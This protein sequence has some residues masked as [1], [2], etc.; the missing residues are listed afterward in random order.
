[1]KK[2]RWCW[3]DQYLLLCIPLLVGHGCDKN[4]RRI[5]GVSTAIIVRILV[6]YV[7]CPWFLLPFV[8][9]HLGWDRWRIWRCDIVFAG[10]IPRMKRTMKRVSS[11]MITANCGAI[12]NYTCLNE[13]PMRRCKRN[14]P[15][16]YMSGVCAVQYYGK[17]SRFVHLFQP[18]CINEERM[19]FTS[20]LVSK[21]R[22][23][24]S[25]FYEFQNDPRVEEACGGEYFVDLQA[26]CSTALLLWLVRNGIIWIGLR[27]WKWLQHKGSRW[28]YFSVT[29][30]LSA[31]K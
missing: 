15:F 28:T 24:V 21:R 11:R 29:R 6:I 9:V 17:F 8:I 5:L 25:I 10:N 14:I 3:Y 1:M 12:P 2:S 27:K 18:A 16:L 22:V 20:T 19:S 30:N 13:S 26:V 31:A 23:V 7:L 4:T